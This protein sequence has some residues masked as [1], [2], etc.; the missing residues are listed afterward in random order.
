MSDTNPADEV[1]AFLQESGA[2]PHF[3]G[4]QLV[5]KDH[6]PGQLLNIGTLE[7][8]DG[9][10]LS[11]PDR[12]LPAKLVKHMTVLDLDE[13]SA[14]DELVT[15]QRV[16]GGFIEKQIRIKSDLWDELGKPTKITV[17]VRPGDQLN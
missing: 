17:T 8:V 6:D 16:D 10:Q 9:E 15:F 7:E 13:G 12:D 11:A 2:N 5:E 14:E 4:E 1:N 3:E